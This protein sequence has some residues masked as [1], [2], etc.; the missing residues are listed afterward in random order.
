MILLTHGSHI[1]DDRANKTRSVQTPFD[2]RFPFGYLFPNLLNDPENLLAAKLNETVAMLKRL[3]VA[4]GDEPSPD[5]NSRL[6]AAYTYF[7]QFVDHDLTANTD[8]N[9]KTNDITSPDIMPLAPDYVRTN[10]ENLRKP[11]LELDSVY[12]SVDLP[13]L[14]PVLKVQPVPLSAGEGSRL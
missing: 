3:G 5:G 1:R 13:I 7:G 4:M 8:R 2:G 12:Q 10:L 14:L 9:E 11:F 6:P